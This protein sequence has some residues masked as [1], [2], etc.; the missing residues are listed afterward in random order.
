MTAKPA[1]DEDPKAPLTLDNYRRMF[2]TAR[3]DMQ[4]GRKDS[5]LSRDFYDGYQLTPAEISVLNARGQPDIVIN[6]VQRAID[7]IMGVTESSKTDPRA[8]MR[9]PPDDMEQSPQ[10]SGLPHPPPGQ[11]MAPGGAPPASM[12][13]Q[14]GASP[15]QPAP[16]KKLDAGDVATMTLRFIEDTTRFQTTTKMDVLENGLIEGCGASI[17]EVDSKTDVTVTQIRWEEY[18]YDPKSRRYDFKDARYQGIAKWMYADDLA[19]LYPKFKEQILDYGRNVGVNLGLDQ[20]YE[21]RPESLTPWVDRKMQRIMVVDLYH[22]YQGTWYRCVFYAGNILEAGPSAYQDDQGASVCPIEG[23]S[24]YINRKNERY[25]IVKAMRDP[26]REL[27]MR[28]SKAVHEINTR[29]IQQVDPNAPPIDSDVARKEAARP[30]GVL[31]SGWQVVPRSDVV[32]N[33]IE[34]MNDAKTEMERLGAAPSVLARQGADASG[35]AQQVRQQAGIQEL[36]RV[37]NRHGEWENRIYKQMWYR[38]RQF[39]KDEKWV[40]VTNDNQAPKYLKINE[41][42]PLDPMTGQPAVDPRTGQPVPGK[43]H[44]AEMDVDIV[45]DKV[46]DTSTLEQEVFAELAQLA[47]V[48]GPQAVP[49]QIML[50]LSS[51]PKKREIIEK[52]EQAQAAQAPAQQ[53]QMQATMAKMQADLAEIQSNIK[54]NNSQADLNEANTVVAAMTA[55]LDVTKAAQLPPGIV[56]NGSGTPVPVV[57]PPPGPSGATT[58]AAG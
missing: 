43:N 4:N 52:L 28:R 32:A 31:P 38:A 10:T 21:D 14:M 44:I 35:R 16:P 11:P 18:F 33:N 26:Q 25:G 36:A 37:L 19:A 2:D 47:Q 9:N 48:Y 8:L 45:I 39:W 50:E 24:A 56:L 12:P 57:P 40:R 7:G 29:Q 22:S 13:P 20:T 53:M 17:V 55:H 42:A 1:P 46:A 54:K 6:R 15:Q 51:I 5:Q 34:M 49:F 3:S 41:P 58:T 23:W 27:N 30:D